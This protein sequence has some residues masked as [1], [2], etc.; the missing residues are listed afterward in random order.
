MSGKNRN[1]SKVGICP[2]LQMGKVH[3][4]YHN[5]LRFKL[6]HQKLSLTWGTQYNKGI[7]IDPGFDFIQ[8]FREAGFFLND[9]DY[10]LITHAHNDH[11]ADLEALTSLLHD[12]NRKEIRGDKYSYKKPKTIYQQMMRK[13]PTEDDKQ[14]EKRVEEEYNRSPRRKMFE[15]ILTQSTNRKTRFI[16]KVAIHRNVRRPC[17]E[18]DGVGN[19]YNW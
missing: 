14:I 8:N 19:S 10:I 15:I 4:L 18:P 1:I 6:R 2:I 16:S 7:V 9:I 12:Y 3:L 11:S 5:F 13:Y 17:N